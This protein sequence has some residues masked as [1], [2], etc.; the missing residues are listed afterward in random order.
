MKKYNY[1]GFIPYGAGEMYCLDQYV[2][3]YFSGNVVESIINEGLG[4]FEII[5]EDTAVLRMTA[6]NLEFRKEV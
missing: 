5:N 3:D 2:E 1:K 4:V 6:Y